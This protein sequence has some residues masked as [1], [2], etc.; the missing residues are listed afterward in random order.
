M[1]RLLQGGGVGA[2]T[3][4]PGP[5]QEEGARATG[6]PGP[7]GGGEL[8]RGP[9]AS[10]GAGPRGAAAGPSGPRK[11][12]APPAAALRPRPPLFFSPLPPQARG[13]ALTTRSCPLSPSSLST[14]RGARPP[15]SPCAAESPDGGAAPAGQRGR[16]EPRGT[17]GAARAVPWETARSQPLTHA[18]L[19]SRALSG[20]PRPPAA[21][22]PSPSARPA[23]CRPLRPP[24]PVRGCGHCSAVPGPKG[25]SGRMG[26]APR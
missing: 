1:T 8:R 5:A 7:A 19:R 3:R 9:A 18:R 26:R 23:G 20:R 2:G 14:R 17:T 22:A 4:S 10:G 24:P 21:V 6:G 11:P 16:G 25:G 13:P 15:S 12:T